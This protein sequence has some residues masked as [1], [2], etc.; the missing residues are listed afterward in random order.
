MH[1]DW[2]NAPYNW[3]LQFQQFPSKLEESLA[4]NQVVSWILDGVL[5]VGDF[6]SDIMP[7]DRI[8]DA[9]EKVEK[10]QI[11]KKCIIQYE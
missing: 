8:L 2:T 1:I 4:H 6:I 10:R 3:T 7:F 5:H 9:F 11:S